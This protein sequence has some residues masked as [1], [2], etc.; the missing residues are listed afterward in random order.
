[1]L[2]YQHAYHAGNFADVHKHIALVGLMQALQKKDSAITF[3]DTHA[4][5]GLYPLSAAA[6]QKTAE[7]ENGVARLWAQRADIDDPLLVA[8]LTRLAECQGSRTLRHYPG[9]PWW[10]ERDRRRQDRLTLFERH[11]AEYEALVAQR[12]GT[13]H[14]RYIRQDDGLAGLGKLVPVT[15]PRLCVLI[16]PSYE[17]KGDY[18]A[19]AKTL[20]HV[21]RKVRHAVVAVWY[22]LLAASR[23]ETMHETLTAAG[24]PKL[25]CSELHVDADGSTDQ[26]IK[27]SG[28]LMLNP[29]WQLDQRLNASFSSLASCLGPDVRHASRWLTGEKPR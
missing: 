1:M 17:V 24:L 19:V 12:F 21:A 27:G 29:P 2:S 22:P 20:R 28:L 15:T 13:R 7:Y 5:R 16:D 6:S 23:H 10:L 8:W 14:E 25:W 11:P 4:G 3:V 18:K 9:S 26:G